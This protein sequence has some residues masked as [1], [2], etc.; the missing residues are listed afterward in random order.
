MK[1][2][3]RATLIVAAVAAVALLPAVAFAALSS[4]SSN[5][6]NAVAA[7]VLRAPGSL[8]LT[9]HP[10][11]NA[12]NSG[13][14]TLT[15]SDAL[16]GSGT[17]NPAGYT[18]ERR[19]SGSTE[20]LPVA[21][22]THAGA[23][24]SGTCV[25]TDPTAEFNSAYSYRVR[26][27]VGNWT[28]GPSNVR[29]AA[30]IAPGTAENRGPLT[31]RLNS[32]AQSGST[33]VA[34]GHGGRILVCSISCTSSPTWEAA[35][36][37]TTND[38][39]RVV[40]DIDTTGRAWA[41]G[42]NGTVLTCAGGCTAAAATWTSVDAGT[43]ADLYGVFATTG[44]VALVG[45]NRTMRYTTQSST[46]NVWLPGLVNSDV[47]TPTS[48]LYAV[49]GQDS[50]NVVVV[51]SRGTGTTGVIAHCTSG[52]G[53]SVC[54]ASGRPIALAAY[55]SGFQ[56]PT[57]DMRDVD[58]V[59]GGGDNIYAV[60]GGGTVYVS[61]S[62]ASGY[63]TRPSNTTADL[64]GVVAISKDAAAAVGDPVSPG[65]SVFL[66]CPSNCAGNNA[67]WGGTMAN[68][69]TTN[70]LHAVAGSSGSSLWAVGAGGTI[71]YYNG[72]TW[73]AQSPP[74]GV[75]PVD[76]AVLRSHDANRHP[77]PTAAS[78][79]ATCTTPAL[80]A[81]ATVPAR[82]GADVTAPMVKVT[83]GYGF[84]GGTNAAQVLLSTDGGGTWHVRALT[85]NVATT[86]ARTVDFTGTVPGSDSVRDIRL[87]V[88]GT[89]GG[90]VMNVD[91]V[92]LDVEE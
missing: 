91:L 42:A 75:T 15:W 82:S 2:T 22:P 88:Q 30:S 36:S 71:Q 62:F 57:A 53:S 58:Y 29:L 90:G 83:I 48:T 40:F 18:I 34:V 26:S 63:R 81:T 37:P 52:G 86:T 50:K 59:S 5:P 44:Y 31:T 21:T 46:F 13:A 77:L 23:C 25:F 28:A 45:A 66:R 76:P 3:S 87:C 7:A 69:G 84:T 72:T 47:G 54:G 60:G 74:S 70:R 12:T 61:P 64:Y 85:P 67:N 35:A 43:T 20:W 27:S 49:A 16:S 89:G 41:V 11:D 38:L 10:L 1:L 51:G 8:T 65:S 19:T 78:L 39:N 92:H 55:A 32:V 68:T 24:A 6:G 79:S 9:A 56:A 17:V 4:A 14:V 33:L 80:V 73:S